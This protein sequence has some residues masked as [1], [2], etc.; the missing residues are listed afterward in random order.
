MTTIN[1]V[2]VITD[3]QNDFLSP[4][5]VTWGMV[6]K[7]VTENKTVEHIE[8]LFKAAKANQIPGL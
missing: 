7:S 1:T 8:E 2:L 3:Q 6:G 4:K 5:G